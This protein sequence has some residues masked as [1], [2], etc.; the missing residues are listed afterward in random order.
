MIHTRFLYP[1]TIVAVRIGL[2]C[3]AVG[4]THAEPMDLSVKRSAANRAK[5]G[6]LKSLSDLEGALRKYGRADDADWVAE[7]TA[8]VREA[9]IPPPEVEGKSGSTLGKTIRWLPLTRLTQRIA[10]VG[11]SQFEQ[12]VTVIID[13]NAHKKSLF[14]HAD[15]VVVYD[16]KGK[17]YIRFRGRG[18]LK[19]GMTA[20]RVE[21]QIIGDGKKLWSCICPDPDTSLRMTKEFD[22]DISGVDELKLH[23]DPLG[24]QTGDWSLWVNPEIGK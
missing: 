24:D 2:L 15:S 10:H 16:I 23:V 9:E 8:E 19:D 22:V 1:R 3:M 5:D 12:D 6:Y 11:Y 14:A 17:G 21:F 20:S 18:G 7:T 13:G 4:A